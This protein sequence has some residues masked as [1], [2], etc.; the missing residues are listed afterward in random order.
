MHLYYRHLDLGI[1]FGISYTIVGITN[2]VIFSSDGECGKIVIAHIFLS[3]S[4]LYCIDNI[5][6]FRIIIYLSL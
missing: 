1:V 4:V 6:F 5:C 2:N 3:F